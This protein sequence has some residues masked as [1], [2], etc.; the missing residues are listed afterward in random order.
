[1]W[2]DAARGEG[3]GLAPGGL[4]AAVTAGLAVVAGRAC[5]GKGCCAE[6]AEDSTSDAAS[7]TIAAGILKGAVGINVTGG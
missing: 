2:Q 4:G 3:A 5:A 6:V 1:L 7:V